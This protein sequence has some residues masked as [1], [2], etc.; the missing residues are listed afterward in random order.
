MDAGLLSLRLIN[1]ALPNYCFFLIDIKIRV[2]LTKK[3]IN[4]SSVIFSVYKAVALVSV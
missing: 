2:I 1:V 3:N 4:K